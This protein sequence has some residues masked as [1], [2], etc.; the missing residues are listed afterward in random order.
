[1]SL[2]GEYKLRVRCYAQ[3]LGKDPVRIALEMDGKELKTHSRSR[4]SRAKPADL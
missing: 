4:P 2:P 1:M 3:P